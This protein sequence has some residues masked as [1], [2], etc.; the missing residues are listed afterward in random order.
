MSKTNTLL[1]AMQ[2]D[3]NTGVSPWWDVD[4]LEAMI[5][6]PLRGNGSP[7]FQKDR[8]VG[9]MYTIEKQMDKG[10]LSM[11]RTT[12]F[13]PYHQSNRAS[14]VPKD[15]R[16]WLATGVPCS[17]CGTTSDLR[18]DHKDGNKEPLPNAGIGDFQPLC[19]HCNT[20]KREVCKKC[21]ASGLRFDAKSLGYPI[22]W[23]R[24]TKNF[25]PQSPRCLGCYWYD[26]RAFR[27]G[28]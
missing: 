26:P 5:G 14:G 3:P 13:A 16:D 22:S 25:Q 7:F 19:V 11:V 21:V 2:I 18:P 23:T 4:K 15:V 6:F 28:K 24:G 10:K 8:S 20:V 1:D 27:K 12:G 17:M 9:V